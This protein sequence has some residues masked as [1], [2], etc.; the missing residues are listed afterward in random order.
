[1]S[2]PDVVLVVGDVIDDVIVRPRG[3][4]RPD[5]D[6]PAD[7]LRVPGGSGANQAAWLAHAGARTRFAG[8]V[9][10][11]DV[12]RHT[13]ALAGAGVEAVLAGDHDRPTGTIVIVVEGGSRTM[14]TDRG[15]NLG[16]T[17]GDLPDALLDD[18]AVLLVSGYALF[19]PGVLAAVTDLA[20][21][22]RARG[23]AV[24]VDPS[25]AGFIADLGAATLLARLAGLGGVDL[26]LPNAD[27]ARLLATATAGPATTDGGPPDLDVDAATA[28]AA[29]ALRAHA[30]TVVVKCG[31]AGALVATEGGVAAVP[32]VPA[33][34]VD[35]TGAG[36]AFGAGLLAAWTAG[37]GAVA[38]ARAGAALAALAVARTG[39]RPPTGPGHPAG[40]PGGGR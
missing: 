37:A 7:V 10:A 35:P 4:V 6:T 15:A 14:L 12:A 38:A 5:T 2:R 8:R 3:P 20:R 31:A 17:A 16:L 34:V 36:D 13:A 11:A 22:A 39:A 27:E 33:A 29:V 1:M 18:V 21:R 9:G 26:L 23:A 24:V 30:A 40:V 19:D 25:S 28:T 32:A